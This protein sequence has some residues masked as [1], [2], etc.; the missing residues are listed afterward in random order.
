MP[1]DARHCRPRKLPEAIATCT[2][3]V[4]GY[5]SSRIDRSDE[6][7]SDR[8]ASCRIGSVA[9]SVMASLAIGGMLDLLSLR[10]FSDADMV[11]TCAPVRNRR[12]VCVRCI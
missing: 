2:A 6:S 9:Y 5:G 10:A 7:S 1:K 8:A 12:L 3:P 4:S 11:C